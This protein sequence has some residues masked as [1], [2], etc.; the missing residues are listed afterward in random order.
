[1]V[2]RSSGRP[3]RS[4]SGRRRAWL[5]VSGFSLVRSMAPLGMGHL[6]AMVRSSGNV[7]DLHAK[8]FK[9]ALRARGTFK[10]EL[11]TGVLERAEPSDRRIAIVPAARRLWTG[12]RLRSGLGFFH[13][14]S[15]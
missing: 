11:T 10:I 13:H 8:L 3:S 6:L 7:R 9:P 2:D 1:M 15:P 12:Q 14:A 4:S 5:R